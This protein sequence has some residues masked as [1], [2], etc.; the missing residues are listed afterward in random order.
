M[1]LI[2]ASLLLV[3]FLTMS[4]ISGVCFMRMSM[5]FM[6]LLSVLLFYVH[7]FVNMRLSCVLLINLLTLLKRTFVQR[8]MPSMSH[9]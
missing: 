9:L 5:Y 1:N 8:F 6:I 3:H 7:S 4:N 2:N